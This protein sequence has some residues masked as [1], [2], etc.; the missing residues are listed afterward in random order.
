M[1]N[2]KAPFPYFGGK[3]KVVDEVWQRFGDTRNYVEPFCGSCAMLLGR[4][5][6]KGSEV[7]NVLNGLLVNFWRSVKNEPEKVAKYAVSPSST[8]D[9][10]AKHNYV[11]QEK[12]DLLE[13]MS[14]NPKHYNTEIAG[15][16]VYAQS[17]MVGTRGIFQEIIG[18]RKPYVGAG[19]TGIHKSSVKPFLDYLIKIEKRIDNVSI[20]CG[21]WSDCLL[22][23]CTI[24]DA[25]S[26]R[27]TGIFF[28]STISE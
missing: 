28:R 17:T 1:T 5:E 9:L 7:V 24:Q 26:P 23:S 27:T 3:S 20:L 18:E 16:W 12:S 25:K 13:K 21:D 6:I 2:L 10:K 11:Y 8:V 14:E 19:G 15:Y 22:K 4:P